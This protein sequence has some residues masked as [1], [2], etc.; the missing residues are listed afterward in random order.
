MKCKLLCLLSAIGAVTAHA[1]IVTSVNTG[2]TDPGD[3][4][5]NALRALGNPDPITNQVFWDFDDA[6]AM[7]TTVVGEEVINAGGLSWKMSNNHL[8]F[9]GPSVTLWGIFSEAGDV[10]K[11]WAKGS[12]EDSA[13]FV[14]ANFL[15]NKA[16]NPSFLTQT[17]TF[18][19]ESPEVHLSLTDHSWNTGPFNWLPNVVFATTQYENE[20]YGLF[21]FDDRFA[22]LDDHDD[23]IG[24]VR[25]DAA[26]PEP[27]SLLGM[28][29]A[30]S[31]GLLMMRSRSRRRIA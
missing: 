20:N 11:L 4:L 2:I 22:S 18:T 16:P 15:D 7:E 27:S 6:A 14:E 8:K 23:F 17:H 19:T 9:S 26:V 13:T 12:T 25:F 3:I 30:G 29:T 31:I 10:N 21:F 24:L 1:G 28:I 5:A